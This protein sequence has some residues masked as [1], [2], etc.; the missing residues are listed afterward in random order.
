MKERKIEAEVPSQWD[1][2]WLFNVIAAILKLDTH[3]QK[4]NTWFE[5]TK[6]ETV[7]DALAYVL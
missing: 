5:A 6:E 4:T 2:D 3:T 7:S 1:W